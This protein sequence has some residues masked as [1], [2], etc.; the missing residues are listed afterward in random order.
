MLKKFGV[1][2]IHRKIRYFIGDYVI[3]YWKELGLLEDNLC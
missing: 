1:R 3:F 2:V